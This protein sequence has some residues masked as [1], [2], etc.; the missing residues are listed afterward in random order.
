MIVE[1]KCHVLSIAETI[2]AIYKQNKLLECIDYANRKSYQNA[3]AEVKKDP[4]CDPPL[5]DECGFEK[6]AKKYYINCLNNCGP[7]YN[8]CG[9]SSSEDFVSSLY[10]KLIS[11][12]LSGKQG[13]TEVYVDV[14]PYL[15]P[16]GNCC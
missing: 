12:V 3:F 4:C 2:E 11:N 6:I 7:V 14:T 9:S 16:V 15:P 8:C 10:K 1:M 13:Q 5:P